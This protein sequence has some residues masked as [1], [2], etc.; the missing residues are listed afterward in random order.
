MTATKNSFGRTVYQPTETE[1][2]A[3]EAVMEG[4]RFDRA[5]AY[6]AL[7]D[8]RWVSA[9]GVPTLEQVKACCRELLTEACRHHETDHYQLGTGGFTVRRFCEIDDC[10]TLELSF[11][12]VVFTEDIE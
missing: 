5:H 12:P 9:D 8:W 2:R 1:S 6:M 11:T 7:T 3:I 10:A 4:F